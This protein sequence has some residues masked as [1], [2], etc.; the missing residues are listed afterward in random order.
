[1]RPLDMTMTAFGSYAE[2]TNIPFRKI[3][4][5][6][7]LVTGDTGAGK[8]TIFDAICFAL[9]GEA[10]GRDR[11]VD[12]LHC[13]HVP[14]STDTE[15]TL[16]FEQ[17]GKE[18]EVTR[19]IHFSKKRGADG[20]Y[21]D[22]IISAALKEPDRAPTEGA[23]KV[24]ARCQELL[25]LNAEQFRKIVMLAQ[26]EFREFLRA[27][28]DKKNE[29]LGKLFDNS[30][31]LYY[32][33]LLLSARDTLR[34]HRAVQTEQ[35]RTQM[36]SVFRTPSEGG[37]AYLPEH[38]AL[39]ENLTALTEREKAE[40]EA[41]RAARAEL[42]R[43]LEAL[44]AQK[45]AAETVNNLLHT[46][47]LQRQKLADL[48]AQDGAMAQ[49]E[50]ALTRA[51]RAFHKVM[52]ALDKKRRA[53]RALEENAL[54]V[55]RLR[56]ALDACEARAAQAL[57][58]TE[59]DRASEVRLDAIRARLELIGGQLP[60]YA[61]LA[62][63]ERKRQSA[64]L[65]AESAQRMLQAKE[66][67]ENALDGQIAAL[68][69]R[70]DAL[71]GADW[72]AQSAGHDKAQAAERLDALGG[73]TGLRAALTE[74]RNLEKKRSGTL[75]ELQDVTREADGA[76]VRHAELYRLFIAG[77]A[78]LLAEDLR[79]R[80]EREGESACPVCGTVLRREQL[81]QLAELPEETPRQEAVKL[82]RETLDRLEAERSGLEA[83][84]RAL[85]A[86]AEAKKQAAL[87]RA[88][89]LLPGCTSWEELDAADLDG[90]VREA[91]RA[92]RDAGAA[93]ALAEGQQRERKFCA[94]QLDAAEQ[95]RKDLTATTE[96]LR[97]TQRAQSAAAAEAEAVIAEMKKPLLH[98]TEA[99]ARAEQKRLS[100]ER[101]TLSAALDAH[102]TALQEARRARDTCFG[103]LNEKEKATETLSAEREMAGS[104]AAAVLAETGFADAEDAVLALAP[105]GGADGERWL[106]Q[107][108]QALAD[109]AS[110]KRSAREQ[111][112]TLEAQA[113]GRQ[114]VDLTELNAQLEALSEKIA[115]SDAAMTAQEALL[116]NHLGVLARVRDCR[117]K[118]SATD[119]V[120]ERLN[121]LAG[122]AGGVNSES[123]KLSFDRY[124]M[125]AVFRDILEM[126]NRRMALMSGGR[127]ELVHK[128]AADRRNAKAGL[129]IE[130]LDNST[131]LQRPSASLSG[132]ES[133]FTSLALAL[134]L[135]DT[136]QSR[137]GGKT[138]DALFIDEG[139]GTLSDDVLDKALEVLDQLGGGRRLVGIISHVDR[140][141]ESI[142][143]K[144]VVKNSERG[145][146]VSCE[147]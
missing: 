75:R 147:F 68:R 28:S 91:E 111:I 19:S 1:M 51:E 135:S 35:V 99:D 129:E 46:L 110:A 36:L 146:R 137:A 6:L 34:S 117:A 13:D 142:Q 126:A 139:F 44:T 76:A 26:G 138:M 103:S 62:E 89:R 77:Q 9:F 82:A 92:L 94:E 7:V 88:E 143:Q 56:E 74:I 20:V 47:E 136:V 40:R 60:R 118:L 83:K 104:E 107:E 32:Q 45:G 140:L 31:V 18:Y 130:V 70:L 69:E 116:Q 10:S 3:K 8:T 87:D 27:D 106:R 95:K 30:L 101:D 12:M 112:V 84:V 65:S 24:T 96:A 81:P 113:A 22:G 48:E 124:V 90:A 102:Q 93:L 141:N 123:G 78:G 120:W 59:E 64:A 4:N 119:A 79:G 73:K 41:L 50:A 17:D 49:R 105:M 16:C 43:Q 114:A 55:G 109:H 21:G 29:I 98:E 108:R 72:Q 58:Q 133:F 144:I 52:P 53:E 54:A 25:G 71:A 125:G 33:N 132:G 122:L 134:G 5:G 63:Q 131:G 61:E 39:V 11:R 2:A 115:Q 128:T 97:E 86:E 38:P 57:A 15:V 37:E 42:N 14:K 23:G 85:Q 67:E 121:L 127:Y 66:T 145:S 80:L 100:A